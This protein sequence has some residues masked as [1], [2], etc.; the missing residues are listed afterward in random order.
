[1][2][3]RNKSESSSS[4]MQPVYTRAAVLRLILVFL[5]LVILVA[6]ADLLSD[7]TLQVSAARQTRS[8]GEDRINKSGQAQISAPSRKA[9]KLP[10]VNFAR[11]ALIND[12]RASFILP[13][14]LFAPPTQA[15]SALVN[16][17][18]IGEAKAVTA[19]RDKSLEIQI[20][21]PP[22]NPVFRTTGGGVELTGTATG[23][24]AI[25]QVTWSNNYGDSGVAQGTSTWRSGRI[26]LQLGTNEITV[27]VTDVFNYSATATLLAERFENPGEEAFSDDVRSSFFR[28]KPVT[29]A[30]VDGLAIFEGDIVLGTADELESARKSNKDQGVTPQGA[31]RSQNRY[32][33]RNGIVPYTIGARFPGEADKVED[34]IR[35]WNSF[36]NETGVT[37][38]PRTNQSD[39]INFNFFPL[40][41]DSN[42]GMAGGEQQT[43]VSGCSGAA[44][45]AHEIGHVI[46]LYHEHSRR[47]RD[48]YVRIHKENM[49]AGMDFQ[50]DQEGCAEVDIGAYDYCSIMHYGATEFSKNGQVTI[51]TIKPTNCVIGQSNGLSTKDRMTVRYLY[52]CDTSGYAVGENSSSQQTFVDSYISNGDKPKVGCSLNA[53]H[54][55]YGGQIQDFNGGA[56][57]KGA[58]MKADSRSNVAWIHGGIWNYY[59]RNGGPNQTFW[60][61]S[62]LGYPI[63]DEQRG[64]NSSVSGSETSYSTCENGTINF[65]GTGPRAGQAYVVRSAILTQWSQTCSSLCYAGGPLGMPTGEEV[66]AP[67][68]P[69]QTNGRYQ[70]F[71]AGQIYL[72]SSGSRTNRTY[73]VQFGIASK[74]KELGG[75]GSALGFPISNEYIWQGRARSDFEGGY[76]YWDSSQGR[77]IVIYNNTC[78]APGAFSLSSPSNGQSLSS[79]ASV[80]LSWGTA[81]NADSYD[82]YFGTSS[83][84]PFIANQTG[85][86]RQVNVTAGQT[87]YWKVVSRVNCNSSFNSTAGVW[88]F[89]VQVTPMPNP[90]LTASLVLS[91]S[92]PYTVGQTVTGTF[93]IKNKG[94]APVTF[95][96]L[97]I[98][99]RLN[100]DTNVI[101]FPHWTN[102]TLNPNETLTYQDIFR[103]NQPG[104]YRFFPA[105]RTADGWKI[106]LLNEIGAEPSVV[107]LRNITVSDPPPT[108]TLTIASTNPSNGINVTVSPNDNNGQG[109]GTT[110]FTRTYNHNTV[111]S[112]TAPSTAG[113]NNFQ[114]WQRDGQD[115]SSSQSISVTMDANHTV[116]AVYA[117]PV[118]STGPSLSI[119]SHSNGQTVTTSTITL[120]GTATDSGRG[121]N[122][123]SSVTVNGVRADNDTTTGS[124]TASWSRAIT[125]N[126]GQNTI[127][128]IAKDG[129]SNQNP[130]TQSITVN[131]QS[132]DPPAPPTPN[133]A[134]NITATSATLSWSSV[135][136]ATDYRVQ[137]STNSTFNTSADGRDCSNCIPN[138][139]QVVN[140]PTTSYSLSGLTA[141][142]TYYWRVRA[143]R[144]VTVSEWTTAWSSTGNFTATAACTYSIS[145]TGQSFTSSAAPG[146]V[147]VTA[148]SGCSWTATS[149]A[150][151]ITITSSSN[152]SGNGTVNYTVA[153][154]TSSTSR[155]GTLSIAGQTFTVT[156]AGGVGCTYSISANSQFFTSDAGTGSVNVTAAN[157]CSWTAVSNNTG[158]VTITSG[159]SG[160]GNGTVSYFVGMNTSA[161]SR[162]T[163]LTIAGQTFTVMQAGATANPVDD[164]L[165][166]VRQQYLDFLG[167]EPDQG[168]W[169]YWTNEINKCGADATCVHKRRIGV[170]AAFFYE[171]EFQRTGGYVYRIYRSTLGR[172]P[173]FAEFMQ[174]RP[175]VVEGDT[176]EATKAAYAE[177]FVQRAGFLQKYPV[178]ITAEKFVGDLLESV[179]RTSGVDLSSQRSTLIGLYNGGAGRAA[180]VRTVADNQ[181]FADAV[182]NNAF[183]R[184]EYF[185]YLRRDP[186]AGGEAFWNDV[187]NGRERNNYYGM[188]CAFLTSKEF[189]ERFGL[190]VTRNN[191]SCAVLP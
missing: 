64:Y 89:S 58:L 77:A 148:G 94:N 73:Y 189:Q 84:P 110:Q 157:G 8:S 181:V 151:W 24:N 90:T 3:R 168:G 74:Y 41:C 111:V 185:G 57:G 113:G 175:L 178:G 46:G 93:S 28:G 180:I 75:S 4:S 85:T 153:A 147:S 174:D 33:W 26:P 155:T 182:K 78:N 47:D 40:R 150:S 54:R 86:S 37:L 121:N 92:E 31:G 10:A 140:A 103:F 125:L 65:Y 12:S 21:S 172:P 161:S 104:N 132:P 156:Q 117:A 158:F 169:D 190:V 91:P 139:N 51:E 165:T 145:S 68:S 34:A 53:V 83:N 13:E 120:S 128:V 27:T 129:S 95:L 100:S 44:K 154:N 32:L 49:Q 98:G 183:V 14:Q 130:I 122:G 70:D 184:M 19:T 106:G 176:L 186:D 82:V 30:V 5:C 133:P 29:Y 56:G 131:Y 67:R 99:G 164:A 136:G 114:K 112:L 52:Q 23:P 69:F 2:K 163:A 45:V 18:R 39:Y 101:D 191:T 79:T 55:W 62:K 71:E 81:S 16:N 162:T 80:T 11:S 177:T 109:S 15:G 170:S 166:F 1:M 48:T 102:R 108:R 66:A 118:D 25:A 187:L 115:F 179:Q 127:T 143:G 134:T 96:E 60:D 87:Y 171:A 72:H 138:G 105:Y 36:S 9:R 43:Y 167:R 6:G 160:N 152:G 88:S 97:T 7:R 144:F 123:I 63:E 159:S 146:S 22:F 124:G 142:T 126:Q 42:V 119:T 59:E 141:G 17:Q 35:H 76:I 38:V 20:T 50:F 135:S 137:V 188:V 61:G 149:N 173:T 107:Y 116:T